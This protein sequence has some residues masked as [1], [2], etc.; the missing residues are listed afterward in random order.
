MDFTANEMEVKMGGQAMMSFD[1]KESA[2]N[3]AQNPMAAPFRKMI[4]S[5]VRLLVRAD[6]KVDQVVGLDEWL[7]S[8]RGEGADPAG[9]L[10]TQQFN[11]A[12]S[13]SSP[14]SAT[15]CR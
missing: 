10:M 15:V 6:G 1:S 5:K 12:S 14:I 11:E 2:K 3:D 13:A 8:V 9:Q 7:N 4:G